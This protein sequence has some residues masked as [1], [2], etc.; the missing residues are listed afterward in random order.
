MV[1]RKC[2]ILQSDI[3]LLETRLTNKSAMSLYEKY[4]FRKIGLR[5]DY[6]KTLLG[7]EDAIVYRKL[8]S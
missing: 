5:K 6:Y 7:K 8:L 2:K 1:V 3:L 4:G